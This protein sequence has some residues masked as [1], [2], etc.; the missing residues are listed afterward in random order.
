MN[1]RFYKFLILAAVVF[2]TNTIA[3]AA[4]PTNRNLFNG[5]NSVHLFP[6]DASWNV[7]DNGTWGLFQYGYG[8]KLFKYNFQKRLQIGPRSLIGLGV[9]GQ[10]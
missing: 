8:G 4:I 7:V 10:R 1:Y 9:I 2:F 6:K 3:S 5:Q